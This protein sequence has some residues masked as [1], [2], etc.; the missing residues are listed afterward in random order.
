ME[1]LFAE[2]ERLRTSTDEGAATR[3]GITD[4]RYHRA[5]D[6]AEKVLL[7]YTDEVVAGPPWSPIVLLALDLLGMDTDDDGWAPHRERADRMGW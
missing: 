6:N 2:L 1:F 7:D 5:L 4:A 3:L